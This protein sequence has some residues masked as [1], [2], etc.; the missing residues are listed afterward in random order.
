MDI[1]API[2]QILAL[3]QPNEAILS[4]FMASPP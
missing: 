4:L 1:T 2:A 3:C